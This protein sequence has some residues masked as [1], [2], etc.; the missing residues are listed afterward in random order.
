MTLFD[1]TFDD[2][3]I[4]NSEPGNFTINDGI[5]R[6]QGSQ[7]WL[8]SSGQYSDFLLRTEFRFRTDDTDS[9]IYVRAVADT[10]FIRGWPNNSYQVQLRN[11]I[12][13]SRFGPVGDLFR[14]GTPAGDFEFDPAVS[15]RTSTGTGEW[16]TL[17]IEALG[18]TLTVR[19]NGTLLSR[20]SNIVN[21][22][23]FVGI[24]SELGVIDFRS[25]EILER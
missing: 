21:P 16:Q 8:K 17:E 12:G 7:G 13:E 15:E 10:E 19:L 24:Q 3:S 20:A 22:A 2:W 18:D 9:G 5:L 4:E 14:H 11:P 23:G 25:F 1:G 6:V